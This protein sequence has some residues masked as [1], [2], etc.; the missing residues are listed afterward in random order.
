[1]SWVIFFSIYFLFIYFRHRLISVK[2]K[3]RIDV[4]FLHQLEEDVDL[5]VLFDFLVTVKAAP[6]EC[7]TRTG[8]P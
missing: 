4:E 7:V 1:M 6:H 2:A 5:E 3:N 8:Q